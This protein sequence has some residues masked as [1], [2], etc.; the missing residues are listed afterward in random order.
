MAVRVCVI[1]AGLTGLMALKNL[2]EDGFEVTAFE[3]KPYVGGIWKPTQ[4]SS[5]SVTPSTVL[6][7]SRFRSSISDFPFPEEVDDF[8]TSEQIHR[9]LESYADHFELRPHIQLDAE[10]KDL[11][12]A[13]DKWE[14]E[15]LVNGT[16]TIVQRF[17]KILSATGL[18][19]G[20]KYPK[21]SLAGAENFKGSVIHAIDFSDGSR[22]QNQNVLLVGLHATATDMVKEL[23]GNARKVYIAHRSGVI[24]APRYTPDGRTFDYDMNLRFVAF[25]VF[26]DK[27]FPNLLNA[28]LDRVLKSMSKKAFPHQ[29][30][31]WSLSP[32]QSVAV[33]LP[34]VADELY[35]FLNT[36]FATPVPNTRKVVGPKSIE[37]T[38]G[39]VLE[40]IDAIVYCTGYEF[41]VPLMPPEYNPYPIVGE[42]P[43]LYQNIFP[44][45]PDPAV[46]N[47]LAFVG[48]GVT[49]FIGLVQYELEVMAISQ[50]WQ[51]R[52]VL[53]SLSEMKKWREDN[54]KAMKRLLAYHRHEGTFY[55]VILP[56]HSFLTW[57][58]RT[59][60]TGIFDHFGWFKWRGWKLW[61]NEPKLYQMCLG[62]VFSPT[63]WRLFDMGR[64]K[65]WGGARKQL[66][67]DNRIADERCEKRLRAMKEESRKN[68]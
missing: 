21:Q 29:P 43:M 24:L 51:G 15:V 55:V 68:I 11:R 34:L 61:W 54:V 27:W 25:Q 60:G 48:Q 12:R 65:P 41:A 4:D 42:A 10:V 16:Q 1:G 14:V 9:Y 44:L 47:S 56:I 40:D 59:A 6:N 3:K 36:G 20:P 53:P 2:K 37:L 62:G 5:L 45:H 19:A 52:S 13:D 67:E 50:I 7:T 57:L 18:F 38:D 58:D 64:R 17:D 49:S 23:A 35:A 30:K 26:A 8:P 39:R 46:R 66:L 32:A 33:S 22:Y 63:I 28:F 31:E